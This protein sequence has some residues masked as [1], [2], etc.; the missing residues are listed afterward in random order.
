MGL[1]AALL[2]AVLASQPLVAGARDRYRLPAGQRLTTAQGT[3]QS[4]TL[5]DFKVLLKMDVDL[6]SFSLQIPKYLKVQEDLTKLSV[7]LGKQLK[8]K[9]KTITVLQ[10]E[11]AR[12]T[13]KWTEENRLRHLAE[14]KVSWTSWFAWGAAGVMTVVA[15]VLAGILFVK[16]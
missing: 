10:G 9:D 8:L 3:F 11:R 5:E 6:E 4:F 1:I 12:L 16:D 14:N 2:V 15:A 13:K 7:N